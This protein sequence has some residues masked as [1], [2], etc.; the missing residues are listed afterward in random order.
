[1]MERSLRREGGK[2]EGERGEE[3]EDDGQFL[4]GGSLTLYRTNRDVNQPMQN[5]L[6]RIVE[7]RIFD[8]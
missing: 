7:V 4:G 5:F 6:G 2:R 3:R 1:M 8:A